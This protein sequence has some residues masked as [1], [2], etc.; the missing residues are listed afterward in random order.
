MQLSSNLTKVDA[1]LSAVS[2]V[3]LLGTIIIQVVL[4]FVFQS[5]LM[6]AEEFTRYM[7]I[8]LVMTPLAFAERTNSH[9]VMEEVQMLLPDGFRRILRMVI[10]ILTTLVY[11][12]VAV[13]SLSVLM[14]NATNRT[15]TLKMPF[16]LF[17]L[18]MVIGMVLLTIVRIRML[19]RRTWKDF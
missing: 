3:V 1:F 9:V 5:P 12:I 4:R 8:C 2:L 6:G 7:V 19:F 17:F 13:S 11:G 15:A 18:P 10:D 14:N 16:W